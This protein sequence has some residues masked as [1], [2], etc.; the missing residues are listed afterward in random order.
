MPAETYRSSETTGDDRREFRAC[1]LD[2][3]HDTEV[4]KLRHGEPLEAAW[5]GAGDCGGGGEVHRDVER[6]AVIRAALAHLEAQRGD[7]RFRSRDHH[8]D[9]G[10]RRLS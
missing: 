8:I 4:G 2:G 7:L 5:V 9:S 1:L 3:S 6:E 10:C